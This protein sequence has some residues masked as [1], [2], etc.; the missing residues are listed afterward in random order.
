[1]EPEPDGWFC[2]SVRRYSTFNFYIVYHLFVKTVHY[3]D[4]FVFA[5]HSLISSFEKPLET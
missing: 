2:S 5:K 1:M 3:G 4:Y